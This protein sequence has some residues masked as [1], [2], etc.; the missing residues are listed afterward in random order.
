MTLGNAN[1]PF[2]GSVS[3]TNN[4]FDFAGAL[5]APHFV[6]D[7][8]EVA[9]LAAPETGSEQFDQ[10]RFPWNPPIPVIGGDAGICRRL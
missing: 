10:L 7:R 9:Y 3:F 5:D 8:R 2:N 4:Q 1:P 6:Q